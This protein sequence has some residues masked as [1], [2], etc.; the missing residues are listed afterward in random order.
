MSGGKGKPDEGDTEQV[1]RAAAEKL[2]AMRGPFLGDGIRPAING[3]DLADVL[4]RAADELKAEEAGT[5]VTPEMVYAAMKES[6]AQGLLPNRAQG[7]AAYLRAHEQVRAVL[8]AGIGAAKR[9]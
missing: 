8:V 3:Y 4:V 5:T 9:G 2:K 7:E 6:V 1:L